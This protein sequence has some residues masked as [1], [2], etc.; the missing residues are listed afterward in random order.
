KGATALSNFKVT[1]ATLNV[2]RHFIFDHIF[3]GTDVESF[4][5][6]F[7]RPRVSERCKVGFWAISGLSNIEIHKKIN[8]IKQNSIE[9]KQG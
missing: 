6:R 5:Y 3:L 7:P 8:V 1:S 9:K 4:R 2:L